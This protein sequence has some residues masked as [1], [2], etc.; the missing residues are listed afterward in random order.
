MSALAPITAP[1]SA[2]ASM[3]FCGLLVNRPGSPPESIVAHG[4]GQ[5]TVLSFHSQIDSS[6]ARDLEDALNSAVAEFIAQE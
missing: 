5:Q 6:G 3:L 4:H 1:P 2:I